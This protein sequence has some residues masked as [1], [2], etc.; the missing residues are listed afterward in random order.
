MSKIDFSD[1]EP[2]RRKP[3]RKERARYKRWR[4]YLADSKLCPE[5]QRRR[6]E[7]FTIQGREP[8]L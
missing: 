3:T 5:E 2:R 1:M 8:R 4:K 7:A 6:A